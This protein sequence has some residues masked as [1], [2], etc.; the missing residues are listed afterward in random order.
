MEYSSGGSRDDELICVQYG[1]TDELEASD[2]TLW[3]LGGT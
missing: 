3:V 2:R 1:S